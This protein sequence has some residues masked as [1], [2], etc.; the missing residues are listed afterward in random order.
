LQQLCSPDDLVAFNF[1]MSKLLYSVIFLG[2]WAVQGSHVQLLSEPTQGSQIGDLDRPPEPTQMRDTPE[3]RHLER[4]KETGSSSHELVVTLAQDK[5]CGFLSGRP[6]IPITCDNG[7]TC[8]WANGYPIMC[9]DINDI[10]NIQG[11]V[12]CYDRAIVTNPHL[13][14]DTCLENNVAL[15]W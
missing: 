5:T 13:C 8:M 4:R 11:N 1:N 14:N 2:L 3:L 15:R 10:E 9:G 12:R 6:G 7:P